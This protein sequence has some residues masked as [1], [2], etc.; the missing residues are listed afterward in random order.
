[1][2]YIPSTEEQQ[3]EMLKEIGVSSFEELITSIPEKVRLKRKLNLPPALAEN[4]LEEKIARIAQKNADFYK[5]KPLLG[6]GAYRHFIPE[7][8][9]A[10]LQRE[11]FWTCYTPYQPELSQGTLQA[12]FEFQSHI[13]RLTK[14]E[15]VVPSIFD[16]ASATAEAALMSIRLTHKNKILVSS[17]LHPHYREV[18]RTYLE[19]HNIQIVELPSQNGRTEIDMIKHFLDDSTAAIIIQSPNFLGGIEHIQ[20]ITEMI[21]QNKGL[22][23]QVIAEAMSLGILKSPGNMNVDIVAGSTQSFGLDLNFGGPY[24]AF[25]ATKKEFIRQLPGRIV[26]ET[27]DKDGKRCFVMTFRA[28]EQDIRRE[29]ATSNMCTNHNLNVIATDIYL[30]LLGTEGLYQYSL[31]NFKKSHYLEQQLLKSGKFTN[32]FAYTYYNEFLINYQG[33]IES[34]QK[35][36][37]EKNFIPPLSIWQFY[38]E[39]KFKQSLLFA[40][41]E[42]FSRDELN[43]ITDLLSR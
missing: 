10:L 13:S 38:P 18:V 7:A 1:M 32:P 16:G 6:A 31:I 30:S 29:K 4:E 14:M 43:K 21:H 35:R 41:T 2:R 5:M 23:I 37:I 34:L 22:L 25:L 42:I 33:D 27:K 19:P 15:V 26:G 3:R 12:I 39:E 9:K 20:E 36:L 11:E 17:L 24:N 8:E 40:V 28:R